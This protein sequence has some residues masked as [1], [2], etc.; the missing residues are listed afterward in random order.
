MLL[1]KDKDSNKSME[2]GMEAPMRNMKILMHSHERENPMAPQGPPSC[3]Y[4]VLDS[5]RK[6]AR[7][8]ICPYYPGG[9]L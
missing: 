8:F 3:K 2:T 9:L 5:T 1:I 6:K 4:A 7:C